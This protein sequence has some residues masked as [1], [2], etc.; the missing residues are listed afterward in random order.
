MGTYTIM[1]YY[2]HTNVDLDD[3]I[4]NKPL[5]YYIDKDRPPITLTWKKSV[6]AEYE[7]NEE[8]YTDV[9]IKRWV[10]RLRAKLCER[11]GFAKN[12][13]QLYLTKALSVVVSSI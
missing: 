5:S 12:G 7:T 10:Q 11:D 8:I 1:I 3:V 6:V 2:M 13:G 9:A 4:L